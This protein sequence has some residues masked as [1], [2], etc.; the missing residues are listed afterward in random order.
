MPEPRSPRTVA[1][2]ELVVELEQF[3]YREARMLQEL[4]FDEWLELFTEDATY[5]V[6]LREMTAFHRSGEPN[7]R[8]IDDD[9]AFDYINETK[10][11]LTLRVK[12]LMSG[13]AHVEEPQPVT[14]RLI[15]NVELG[16]HDGA[17]ATVHSN[18][19]VVRVKEQLQ[20][21]SFF[22]SRTDRLVRVD[23]VW[24]IGARLVVFPQR[25]LEQPVSML[26]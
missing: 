11:E 20:P 12:R 14:T 8:I 1:D 23:D 6:P 3:Y 17:S 10:S 2:V 15:T 16:E 26:F 7:Q 22:G 4:R 25:I 13:L 9:L 21:Q 19:H 24:R 5:R 18:F